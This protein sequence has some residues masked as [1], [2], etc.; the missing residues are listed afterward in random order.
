MRVRLVRRLVVIG[1]S[2]LI[3][4]IVGATP[5]SGGSCMVCVSGCSAPQN[6]CL[7]DAR[8]PFP[9][10]STSCGLADTDC[11]PQMTAYCYG[12]VT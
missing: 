10:Y 4:A 7:G 6:Q 1:S 11:F 5:S 9:V 8:C 12:G 2:S 3:F